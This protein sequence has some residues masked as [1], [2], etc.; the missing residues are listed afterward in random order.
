MLP[1]LRIS[2]AGIAIIIF[3]LP[4][5]GRGSEPAGADPPG[6]VNAIVDGVVAR[7]GAL[8]SGRIEYHLDCGFYGT[9]K[10]FHSAAYRLSLMGRSWAERSPVS[11]GTTIDHRGMHLTYY[12]AEKADGGIHRVANIVPSEPIDKNH[13]SPPYFA[14][15]IWIKGCA[16]YIEQHR[17]EAKLRGAEPL[18]GVATNIVEWLVD[19]R[20]LNTAFAWFNEAMD[21]GGTLRL[22]VAPSLGYALPLIEYVDPAGTAQLTFASSGFWEAAPGFF[23]PRLCEFRNLGKRE[24]AYYA[25]YELSKAEMVNEV[26]PEEDFQIDL[27]VGTHINDS[28]GT[29]GTTV[30]Q[31]SEL[32]VSE[33][34][35]SLIRTNGQNASSPWLSPVAIGSVVGVVLLTATFLLRQLR[36]SV[37]HDH[38]S[39]GPQV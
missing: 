22:H 27:P 34:I 10:P 8:V 28:R 11:P 9:E 24:A 26:V 23:L 7:A 3:T 19:K 16:K 14:G 4:G 12:E 32:P 20:D 35:G 21:N 6:D 1:L 38:K 39:G 17:A 25:R 5:G 33:D 37:G 18:E 36:Q 2:F 13:P 31:V 29:G 30:I 15:T